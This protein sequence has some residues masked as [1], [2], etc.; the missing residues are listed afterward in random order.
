MTHTQVLVKYNITILQYRRRLTFL[1]NTLL[2]IATIYEIS[3]LLL[4]FLNG[5]KH[6]FQT[7]S[8]SSDCHASCQVLLASQW[9]PLQ[10]VLP[11]SAFSNID[12]NS[13]QLQQLDSWD[14]YIC[15]NIVQSQQ[16]QYAEFKFQQILDVKDISLHLP[17]SQFNTNISSFSILLNNG[18]FVVFNDVVYFS[19]ES[20]SELFLDSDFELGAH[21]LFSSLSG[22]EGIHYREIETDKC[23]QYQINGKQNQ[24]QQNDFIV[25]K[26]VLK[27]QII[28]M[29]PLVV[30]FVGTTTYLTMAD[31]IS[32]GFLCAA[33]VVS[34]ECGMF[35]IWLYT[36]QKKKKASRSE[37]QQLVDECISKE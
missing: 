9:F 30:E 27:E 29:D 35:Y 31:S 36:S 17:Q 37:L 28:E 14:Y 20:K 5:W 7:L 33:A 15:Q 32:I 13:Y 6:K 2:V 8:H 18:E 34:L 3:Q 16:R 11:A 26:K 19:N 21:A 4:F 10:I 23:V 24:L 12:L 1:H 22:V 25:I